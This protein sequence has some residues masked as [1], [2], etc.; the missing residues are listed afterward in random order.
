M[1]DFF[2]DVIGAV[3]AALFVGLITLLSLGFL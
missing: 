2:D 1:S 3:S